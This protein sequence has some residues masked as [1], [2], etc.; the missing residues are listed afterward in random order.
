MIAP[1][2]VTPTATIWSPCGATSA[3]GSDRAAASTTEITA[4]P[5]AAGSSVFAQDR[6]LS[7]NGGSAA[8]V[9]PAWRIATGTITNARPTTVAR[10]T[11]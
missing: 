6:T 4:R 5:R 2:I 9:S 3:R 1:A 11:P 7:K 8:S 10:K